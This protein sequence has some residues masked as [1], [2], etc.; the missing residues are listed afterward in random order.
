MSVVFAIA[1]AVFAPV[2]VAQQ[3]EAG[4]QPIVDAATVDPGVAPGWKGTI[5]N[6][7]AG[8]IDMGARS[9]STTLKSFIQPDPVPG[10]SGTP[11]SYGYTPSDPINLSDPT[12]TFSI[13]SAVGLGVRYTVFGA[14]FIPRAIIRRLAAVANLGNGLPSRF[15]RAQANQLATGYLYRG[16]TRSPQDISAAGGFGPWGNNADW[17][18]HLQGGVQAQ[19]G[20]DGFVSTTTNI[21]LAGLFAGTQSPYRIDVSKLNPNNLISARRMAG[22]GAAGEEISEIAHW[23]KIPSDAIQKLSGDGLEWKSLNETDFSAVD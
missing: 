10:G 21:H 22:P 2:A 4:I 18:V 20:G 9:F 19:D 14:Y 1:G 12:G 8:V 16:D 23:G 13:L 6:L 11:N 5:P 7:D 17:A 3:H 15:L